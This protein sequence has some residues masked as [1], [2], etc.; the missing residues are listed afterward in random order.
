MIFA[1]PPK[2]P[3][4]SFLIELHWLP[5]IARIELKL[6]AMTFKAVK[7]GESSYLSD[8]LVP[9]VRDSNVEL[10]SSDDPFHM[11]E[12]RALGGRSLDARSFSFS[13]PG[14]I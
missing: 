12:P 7:Y 2:T 4:I 6:C 8:M 1:A 10:C 3:T 5:V 14:L 11:D 9:L 13:A